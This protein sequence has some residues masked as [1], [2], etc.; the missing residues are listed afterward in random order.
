MTD[1]LRERIQEAVD[2]AR[3]DHGNYDDAKVRQ[4]T[5]PSPQGGQMSEGGCAI[6]MAALAVMA[7]VVGVLVLLAQG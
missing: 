4:G 1:T 6:F 2:A 5:H 7:L 3:F